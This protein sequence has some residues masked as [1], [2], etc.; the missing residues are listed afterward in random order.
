M[1][2]AL[3]VDLEINTRNDRQESEV[4]CR[5]SAGNLTFDSGI[6]GQTEGRD[7]GINAAAAACPG[8]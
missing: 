2:V 3:G 4:F 5:D 7:A 8:V 1:R 6:A